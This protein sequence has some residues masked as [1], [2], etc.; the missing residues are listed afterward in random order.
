MSRLIALVAAAATSAALFTATATPARAA[1]ASDYYRAVPVAAPKRASVVT[2]GTLWKCQD[3]TCMAPRGSSR[4]AVVCEL[5]VQRLGAL[6][7]FH[8]NGSTF[9]AAALE[10][11][12]A[13]AK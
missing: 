9:D 3:G 11:C 5:A 2:R 4:D 8:A 7:A 10:R 1:G 13:R 6:S 12:N